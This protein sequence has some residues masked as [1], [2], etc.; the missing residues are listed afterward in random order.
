MRASG[1]GL[2]MWRHLQACGIPFMLSA[3]Y[4]CSVYMGLVQE[5]YWPVRGF[6]SVWHTVEHRNVGFR[7]V[8]HVGVH[9]PGFD[10]TVMLCQS[11]VPR[12]RV[13]AAHVRNGFRV[14]GARQNFYVLSLYRKPDCLL[15]LTDAEQAGMFVSPSS[16]WVIL[17]P[18]VRSGW[19]LRKR[20]VTINVAVVDFATMSGCDQFIVHK[21]HGR[22]GTHN[23]LITVVYGLVLVAVVSTIGNS[24]HSS[25][26]AVI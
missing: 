5:P 6:V 12:S 10:R 22:G 3:E 16:R 21:I 4:L 1:F 18:I 13:F 26:S 14:C 2:R 7:Y 25:L 15:T 19:I 23:H 9:H 8:S 17:M 24:D 20:I 11:M